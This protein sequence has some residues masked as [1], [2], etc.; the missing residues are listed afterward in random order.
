[1]KKILI[2]ASA[3]ALSLA[4][5]AFASGA[6]LSGVQIDTGVA[7]SSL[8]NSTDYNVTSGAEANVNTLAATGS[9]GGS[10]GNATGSVAAGLG[11]SSGSTSAWTNAGSGNG[12][13]EALM[14]GQSFSETFLGNG[15]GTNLTVPDGFTSW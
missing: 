15:A 14:I 11:T 3:L 7:G 4:A 5:P 2:T 13:A 9:L 6:S 8:A 10:V 12:S 1:M